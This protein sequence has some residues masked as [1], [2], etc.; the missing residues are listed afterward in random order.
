MKARAKVA[1]VG[2]VLSITDRTC[3]ELTGFEARSWKL[4]LV[5]LAVPHGRVGRRT[6]CRAAD[7]DAAVARRTGAAPSAYDEGAI[8]E[9]AARRGSR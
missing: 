6:I 3:F 9:L 8:I 4:A 5:D 7:W 1:Q 2:T